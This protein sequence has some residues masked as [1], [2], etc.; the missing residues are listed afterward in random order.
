MIAKHVCNCRCLL[1]AVANWGG[2][3]AIE[4]VDPKDGYSADACHPMSQMQERCQTHIDEDSSCCVKS[5]IALRSPWFTVSRMLQ[6]SLCLRHQVTDLNGERWAYNCVSADKELRS[7]MDP[8]SSLFS[9]HLQTTTPVGLDYN[10]KKY[11]IHVHALTPGWNSPQSTFC[12]G[13]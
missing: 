11:K 13:F 3:R 5:K 2:L 1:T 6:S 7:G 9:N 10:C 8:V 12:W 4:G